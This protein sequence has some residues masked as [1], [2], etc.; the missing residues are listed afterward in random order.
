MAQVKKIL[1]ISLLIL[2]ALFYSCKKERLNSCENCKFYFLMNLDSIPGL[3]TA[4]VGYS[5]L[6]ITWQTNDYCLFSDTAKNQPYYL[7]KKCE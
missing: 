1:T 2:S 5:F 4:E 6:E 3:D 7:G